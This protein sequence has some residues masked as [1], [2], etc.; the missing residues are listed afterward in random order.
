MRDLSDV[1]SSDGTMLAPLCDPATFAR[2]FVEIGAPTR[3]SGFDL[4]PIQLSIE[5]RDAGELS[6]VAAE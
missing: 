1:L 2:V 4:D 5:L 3:W 6:R